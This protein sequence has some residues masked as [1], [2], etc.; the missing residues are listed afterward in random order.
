M[1]GIVY[2][3]FYIEFKSAYQVIS[4]IRR[5]RLISDEFDF[6]FRDISISGY[7]IPILSI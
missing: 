5:L 6:R 1:E 3:G 7:T 4:T 2:K